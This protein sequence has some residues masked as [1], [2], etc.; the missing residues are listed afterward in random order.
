MHIR[1]LML[2]CLTF[3]GSFAVAGDETKAPKVVPVSYLRYPRKGNSFISQYLWP[4]QVA[5]DLQEYTYGQPKFPK[6]ALPA[7]HK[8]LERN[9]IAP[10][11]WMRAGIGVVM[12][13]LGVFTIKHSNYQKY[14]KDDK[15]N[16]NKNKAMGQ[17][18]CF[19]FAASLVGLA[20]LA[21]DGFT[22]PEDK[23]HTADKLAVRLSKEGFGIEVKPKL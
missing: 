16:K 10:Q 9:S 1:L 17:F 6:E 8:Y 19:A 5:I 20:D 23:E 11:I 3:I 18:G 14:D 21:R 15:S 22:L 7:R 4:Y 13:L 12:G 2:S